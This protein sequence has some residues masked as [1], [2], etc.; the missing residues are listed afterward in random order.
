MAIS[1][2]E[3]ESNRLARM[4][5][6]DVV[7]GRD[8]LSQGG[9]FLTAA[10]PWGKTSL[11]E[12]L[13]QALTVRDRPFT[14]LKI[15]DENS[16]KL[17]A[18]VWSSCTI[19][20][21]DDVHLLAGRLEIQNLLIR[22]V[23]VAAQRLVFS[24]PH[25]PWRLS[26]LTEALRS[27]LGGGVILPITSPEFELMLTLAVRRSDELNLAVGPEILAALVRRA[28]SDPR[29]L[30]GLLNTLHFIISRGGLNLEAAFARLGVGADE[31]QGK[32][33][34]KL[35]NILDGVAVAFGL[36]VT[37]LIGHS[38]LRQ[39][40]W[41]RRVV[42]LLARELTNLTTTEIGAALGGRDHSTVIH[43]LK[44]IREELKNPTRVRMVENLKRS[45][46]T[47][48]NNLECKKVEPD[49]S[50]TT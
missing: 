28:E 2:V 49:T 41:P 44:K 22:A 35:N 16:A 29:C 19:I 15:G 24:A 14:V 8:N 13:A 21:V 23:D 43:G 40:A 9:L 5:L 25:P 3:G 26:G 12:A 34:V 7:E 31:V 10:G 11:L 36:K 48:E 6:A 18:S 46:L 37:D 4:A 39:D 47:M 38:R 30:L 45:F 32:P 42:M 17:E 1:F 20:I 50:G 33:R 27:R